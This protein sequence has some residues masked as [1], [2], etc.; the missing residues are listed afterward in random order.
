MLPS[1]AFT[2]PRN[3]QI[4]RHG[5]TSHFWPRPRFI[6]NFWPNHFDRPIAG[7]EHR[8]TASIS[9]SNPDTG[10]I[11]QSLFDHYKPSRQIAE[12]TVATSKANMGNRGSMWSIAMLPRSRHSANS[13][14]KVR[15]RVVAFETERT[16]PCSVANSCADDMGIHRPSYPNISLTLWASAVIGNGF[17]RI[18]MPGSRC[19]FPTAAFSA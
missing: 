16:G 13:T 1:T 14:G 11:T 18:S 15:R 2:I 10:P 19:P 7:L 8:I 4:H 17:V 12:R 5:A 6:V 3:L 9:S